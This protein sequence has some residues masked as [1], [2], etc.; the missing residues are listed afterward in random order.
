MIEPSIM[1]EYL[2]RGNK[3]KINKR[4]PQQGRTKRRVREGEDTDES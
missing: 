1:R 3:R 2:K 4:I